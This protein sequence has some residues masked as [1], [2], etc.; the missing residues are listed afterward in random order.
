[1]KRYADPE[2]KRSMGKNKKVIKSSMVAALL[3]S[4]V[5]STQVVQS[6]D[7]VE[8]VEQ[9][10]KNVALS[11]DV[12]VSGSEFEGMLDGAQAVDGDVSRNSRWAAAVDDEQWLEVDLGEV[13]SLN[14]VVLKFFAESP[15]YRVSVSEDGVHYDPILIEEN[16]SNGDEVDKIIEFETRQVRF[17]KY[18]QETL[19]EH[20]RGVSYSSSLYEIE[21]YYDETKR[22]S[23]DFISSE[24]RHV[25]MNDVLATMPNT[26][27]AWVKLD[28]GV[29]N[30][31]VIFGN[32]KDSPYAAFSLEIT[33][34]NQFRYFEQTFEGGE[35]NVIDLKT[36]ESICTGEWIHVGVV[37][38]PGEKTVQLYINGEM[39]VEKT[40]DNVAEN[41]KLDNA[42]FVAT[43]HRKRYFLDGEVQSIRLWDTMKTETEMKEAMNTVVT[44]SEENLLHAWE[45]GFK[46]DDQ[47]MVINDKVETNAIHATA[48]NFPEHAGEQYE[49]DGTDFSQNTYKIAMNDVLA[50]APQTFETWIKMPKSASSA[51]GGVIAGNYFRYYSD[52]I[53]LVNFEIYANGAPRLYW[54]IDG[55]E[56]NYVAENINVCTGQWLHLAIT[57]DTQTNTMKCFINGEKKDE[58]EIAFTPRKLIQPLGVGLD[59]RP[60]NS[61]MN[62]KGEI[63]DLRVWSTTRSEEEIKQNFNEELQDQEGLLGNWK[64][65]HAKE[66]VFEDL[67]SHDND[68]QDTW[69]DGDIIAKAK[70]GYKSIAIIPD[71]Q[72]MSLN[73]PDKFKG[74]TQWMVDHQEEYGIE[75]VMPMG[76]L[77]H[78]YEKLEQWKV[79]RDSMNLL[80]GKIPYVLIPGN[81]DSVKNIRDTKNYNTYFPYEKYAKEETFGGAYEEGKMDNTYSFFTINGVEFMTL[82][83]ETSPGEK[84]I[85]WANQVI[86]DH[87]D[88]KVIIATH[89]Y[90]YLDGN[91]TTR[92]TEDQGDYGD[93]SHSGEDIWNNLAKN[94]KNV[95]LVLSG[96]I[97][98]PDLVMREDTG[99][100]GNKVQQVLCDAQ[101]MEGEYGGLGMVMMFSFKEGSDD[102]QIN[103]YSTVRKQFFRV[104]NQFH[105]NVELTSTLSV[106]RNILKHALDKAEALM[107]HEDFDKLAPAVRGLI[108]NRYAE[109]KEVY[110]SNASKEATLDAWMNLAT[111]LH[112][113]DFKADKTM[114]S[115]LITVCEAMD[116]SNYTEGVEAF[117]EALAEANRVY[118]DQ[119]VLQDSID[120]V[121]R[122][123]LIAKDALVETPSDTVD[124]S[125]LEYTIQMMEGIDA[126]KY[127][128]NAYWDTFEAALADAVLVMADPNATQTMVNS[129]IATLTSAYEDIRLIPD[130]QL[131]QELQDFLNI[132][133]GIDRRLYR[134]EHLAF[135]DASAAEANEMLLTKDF[136]QETY[137]A[138]ERKMTVVLDIINYEQLRD[139]SKEAALTTNSTKTPADKNVPKTGVNVKEAGLWTMITM[140]GLSLGIMNKKKRRNKLQK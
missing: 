9:T 91:R 112:Y 92:M 75:L 73:Y 109:A 56:Y 70:D 65:D 79:A 107:N 118:E 2:R 125:I 69:F 136:T 4:G 44:G 82:A 105:T 135:I 68:I 97:G 12:T 83:M 103:W 7:T 72:M 35:K 81:H 11:K 49:N 132:V 104:K 123:L 32:Y 26:M 21:A 120:H 22:S 130:E 5:L 140:G 48:V 25:V 8:E 33:A 47:S 88:K 76:D 13:Q 114:L 124:K 57:Y 71:P 119:N 127:V 89:N 96:H 58:K 110:D 52:T 99:V 102:V 106:E 19:W 137:E 111:A 113:A 122:N 27:E 121:Y 55:K 54:R 115:D 60:E 53:P 63:A 37:R 40:F 17:I 61:K 116:L 129:A 90:M 16:G 15:I 42:H 80:D 85:A 45:F 24:K 66:G 38:N 20:D 98:Y 134:S 59:G 31:Q 1:M 50:E 93:N 18:E 117:E 46:Q 67:S 36:Q 29:N 126:S 3:L 51:R 10:Q 64:L 28:A 87:P 62:F 101:W 86:A 14:Q 139:T 39:T 84:V 133:N 23:L 100:Y 77:V 43:D 74:M 138:F 30:R 94:Y 131:L 6:N 41:P 95:V 128:K 78:Q 108:E 34:D